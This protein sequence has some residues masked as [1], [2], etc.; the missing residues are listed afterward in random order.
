MNTRRFA[1]TD[2]TTAFREAMPDADAMAANSALTMSLRFTGHT[3]YGAIF[4]VEAEVGQLAT[5]GSNLAGGY[6][7]AGMQ[8]ELGPLLLSAELAAGARAVRYSLL[9][10][11]VTAMIVEPR[12]RGT[13]WVSPRVTFG[14]TVGAALGDRDTW[15]AGLY[16]GIHSLDFDRRGR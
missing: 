1:A 2:D 13:L 15:M 16:F 7:I 6:G 10:S 4:G 14:G 8:G 3:H 11:D 12:V 9:T 5:T